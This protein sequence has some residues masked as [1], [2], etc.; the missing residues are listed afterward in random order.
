MFENVIAQSATTALASDIASGVL[1]PSIL[2]SG[3]PASG[4][5]TAAL[6]LARVLSCEMIEGRWN[7]PC[8]SCER[9]RALVHPDLLLVGPRAFS[10]EIAASA[11]A[12]LRDPS[13]AARFLFL[14]ACR[15]L[16]ARFSPV[17]WEGEEAK[18][19]KAASLAVSLGEDIEEIETTVAGMA[20]GKIA[21]NAAL[22]KFTESAR[23]TAI[24]LESEGVADSTPIAHIRRASYWARMAPSGRRRVVVV[25][26]ADRMQEGARNALLKILEEPPATTSLVLT[27]ARRG[28]M[29]PTILSRVRT[30]PFVLRDQEA[31]RD[32]VRRV[33]RDTAAAEASA[34]P[35]AAGFLVSRYLDSFQP[36]PPDS[37]DAAAAFFV[38]SVAAASLSE[39]RRRNAGSTPAVIVSLGRS[40]APRAEAGG[41]GRPLADPRSACARTAEAAGK[42][43][44][45]SL[46]R[47]F[48]DGVL[49]YAALPLRDGTAGPSAAAL[50][51]DWSMA[52]RSADEAVAVYNQ[53]PALALER[54]FH[55]LATLSS[56]AR[57]F[58]RTAT[59]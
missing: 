43:E 38:S 42:F 59:T 1:P 57:N 40:S 16:L 3:P 5:G 24:K 48:L 9:H 49:R 44:P 18:L 32:V 46:F 27:S 28:A 23:Q 20:S 50:A 26:N 2:L 15:K 10:A 54:L 19:G 39:A 36:V 56:A 47:P 21:G 6:E 35:S 53:S 30:Y 31:E 45:R 11:A 52:V 58:G 33:F 37:L 51:S 41:L 7:C 22:A 14:R 13:T 4:K 55:E 25:E 17:L 8:A 12:F 29:M 34:V